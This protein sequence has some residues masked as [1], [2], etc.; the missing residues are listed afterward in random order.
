MISYLKGLITEL[1]PTSLIIECAGVGYLVH[2]S[3]TT[4]SALQGKGEARVLTTPVIREDAHLLYG[5]A[6]DG[7][8]QLFGLLTSISGIGPNTA[9]VILSQYSPTELNT[10][11]ALGQ[12]EPLKAV[13]GIGLKTAQRI[14]LELKGKIHLGD[15]ST[16]ITPNLALQNVANNHAQE[17]A[18]GALKMLGYPEAAASKVVRQ[19][20]VADPTCAVEQVIKQA[21]KML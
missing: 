10:I 1:T 19:I 6:T 17:E 15:E 21:L 16:T 20:L 8:R 2:I 13:K 12:I 18:I 3:L 14:V 4:Y 11:L 7:E 5:F 9:R